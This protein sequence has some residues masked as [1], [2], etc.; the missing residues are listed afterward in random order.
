M[1]K[2]VLAAW[3]VVAACVIAIVVS[4]VARPIHWERTVAAAVVLGV[5][6]AAVAVY[7]SRQPTRS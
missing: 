4:A 3:L 2:L 7:R 1:S 5:I 6:A